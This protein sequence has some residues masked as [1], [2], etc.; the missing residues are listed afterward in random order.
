MRKALRRVAIV[1]AAVV[2]SVGLTTAPASASPI[3]G[4]DWSSAH[5]I[6]N[7]CSVSRGNL[8]AMWQSI[9]IS[10]VDGLGD[11]TTWVDGVFGPNTEAATRTWQRNHGITADG[12]VGPQT[13]S[14]AFGYIAP[15]NIQAGYIFYRYDGGNGPVFFRKNLTSNV[16]WFAGPI[17]PF[18]D[19]DYPN[20]T[21]HSCIG[22]RS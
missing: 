17:N 18:T 8:V 5:T 14:T 22:I 11:C 19:T 2:A 4:N 12:I 9:V 6:C 3:Q 7:G 20:I 13:W 10:A 21:P 1:A 16:W 15:E